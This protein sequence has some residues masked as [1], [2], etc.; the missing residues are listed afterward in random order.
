MICIAR[1]RPSLAVGNIVGSAI[2]NILGAFSL[3]LL[4]RKD[5]GPVVFDRSSK[6]YTLLLLLLTVLIS[7]L[8]EF[9]HRGVWRIAGGVSIV[10]FVIYAGSIAW[11]ITMGL[12][13][14]PELSDTDSDSDDGSD[15]EEEV[16]FPYQDEGR[17]VDTIDNTLIKPSLTRDT[18]QDPAIPDTVVNTLDQSSAHAID[19][20]PTESTA[21]LVSAEMRGTAPR[22]V[23]RITYKHSV[24]YHI[25]NLVLGFLAIILSSFVLSHAASN[26]VDEFGFSD[27]LFG[28]VVLSVATTL[29]E[30]F[31][32]VISGQRGHTGILVANTVGSNIFLLSLCM[33]I[34]WVSTGGEFDQ[35]SVNTA[36]LGVM[37]GSTLAMTF[38]VWFG[39]HWSRVLGAIM[40][41]AYIAF[42]VLE[43]TV[44]REG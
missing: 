30:K 39:A 35:G 9:G 2:S 4:F 23:G 6:I 20:T 42:L 24:L 33:G 37:L 22:T 28:V 36:E 16:T 1:H 14:A 7:G 19:T 11:S 8:S 40:L 18:I 41:L 31:V 10:L 13:V 3:G 12:V 27:V 44:I 29:P 25:G 32:A 26:I 5:D 17:A 15:D 21:L 34:T 43:F 38:V